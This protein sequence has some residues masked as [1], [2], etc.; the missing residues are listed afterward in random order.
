MSAVFPENMDRIDINDVTGS[1]Q[2]I[3]A[4]IR[5]MRERVEFAVRNV[6]RTAANAGNAGAEIV[7]ELEEMSRNIGTLGSSI[8]TCQAEVTSALKK[9]EELTQRVAKIEETITDVDSLKTEMTEL[10]T[11]VEELETKLKE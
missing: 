9:I 11:K 10:K 5:Y 4:Y 2:L 7:G 6:T 3:D 8:G 1:L